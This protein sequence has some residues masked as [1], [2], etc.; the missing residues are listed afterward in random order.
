MKI[1][2]NGRLAINKCM[3]ESVI[4]DFLKFSRDIYK[5]F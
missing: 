1:Y 3:V 4:D 2:V 5:E